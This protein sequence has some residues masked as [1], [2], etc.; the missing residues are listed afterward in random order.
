MHKGILLSNYA[1]ECALQPVPMNQGKAVHIM[2]Y[3]LKS[4]VGLL[5]YSVPAGNELTEVTLLC[6]H[7]SANCSAGLAEEPHA[8]EEVNNRPI[9][10]QLTNGFTP[11][12]VN[13]NER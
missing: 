1:S 12:D 3:G 10:N 8:L 7:N 4:N 6:G 11:T 2:D 13:G 9:D 5:V